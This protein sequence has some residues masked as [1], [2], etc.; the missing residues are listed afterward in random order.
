MGEHDDRIFMKRFSGV[1]VGLVIVT[2]LIIVIAVG[3]DNT[4]PDA[5]PSKAALAAERVEPIGAV[6]TELPEQAAV[7]DAASVTPQPDAGGETGATAQPDAGGE[8]VDIDGGAI[9]AQACQACHMS[10]AAGAP[11]PGS[12]AWAER[13][14]KGLDTLTASAISGIGVMPP[15]GGRMDLSDEEI[16]AT[17]EHMLAQ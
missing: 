16:R 1:I 12:E 4:D 5:N 6:R 8:A 7:P 9:Y 14:Q 2:I 3:Y 15:K 17:V 10:G 13:A 11:I